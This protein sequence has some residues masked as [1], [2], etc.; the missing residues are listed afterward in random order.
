MTEDIIKQYLDLHDQDL[1]QKISDLYH[2]KFIR[3]IRSSH[4]ND[5]TYISSRV[6]A[7]M[8]KNCI[9]SV[10]ISLDDY[11]VVQEAQCECKVGLGPQA[12]CKHVAVTLLALTH[13]KS[14]IITKET[15]TQQLQT[16]H[17]AKPYGGSPV[18]MQNLHMRRDGSLANLQDFDPRPQEFRNLRNYG[19]DFRNVW[20]NCPVPNL[21]IRQL[22]P[23]ANL[24]A[25]DVDHDCMSKLPSDI[26]LD[27]NKI[28]SI[29][30]HE[31]HTLEI[32]TRGQS[33]NRKW[34]Y[35]RTKRIHASNFGRICKA[36]DKTDYSKLANS[37]T[38]SKDLK[39]S[40]IEHGKQYEKIAIQAYSKKTHSTVTQCGIF[41]CHEIPY[42]GASP[43]G[44]VSD[45]GIVEV[46]CPFTVKD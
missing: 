45:E 29:T 30:K 36:T 32:E 46:K 14:G 28:T 35:E 6:S 13:A 10:D 12:H 38:V 19:T 34:K 23:P 33:S 44:L 4:A 41:V 37:L 17:Q 9:Y 21:P 22:Y 8:F 40:A 43:D 26:F 11:G 25:I 3:S 18:K 1:Q 2:A 5:K 20:I 15:C 39:T 31:I 24:R 7:E 16:F 42:L 27:A